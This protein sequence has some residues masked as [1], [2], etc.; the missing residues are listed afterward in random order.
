MV[1]GRGLRRQQA[2]SRRARRSITASV[3]VLPA[4]ARPVLDDE[5]L[6]ELLA[7]PLGD[8]P[9]RHVEAAARRRGDHDLHRAVGV[10]V[11][12]LRLRGGCRQQARGHEDE[13]LAHCVSPVV[14]EYRSVYAASS[15]P[16]SSIKRTMSATPWPLRRLLNTN[17]RVPRMR[18]VSRS[19]TSSE[20]PT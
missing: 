19:I 15:P 9:R 11:G 1:S 14:P 8:D 20:A 17:G 12:R 4:G 10:I 16:F 2:C 18:R 5:R 7:Q 6:A 13:A 3:P